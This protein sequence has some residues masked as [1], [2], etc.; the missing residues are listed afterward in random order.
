M[1]GIQEIT[2]N[3]DD[4]KVLSDGSILVTLSE[5]QIKHANEVAEARI[6]PYL[7]GAKWQVKPW[8]LHELADD[9]CREWLASRKEVGREIDVA[10]CEIGRWYVNWI[11]PY[12]ILERLGESLP[13]KY[14]GYIVKDWFVR[15]PES[16][17]WVVLSDLPKSSAKSLL[18]RIRRETAE[19]T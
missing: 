2:M 6:A 5:E 13:E 14:D 7:R 3:N 18:D 15:S 16:R 8:R 12:G 9:E 4:M 11:D 10:T 1:T 17:G 19:P